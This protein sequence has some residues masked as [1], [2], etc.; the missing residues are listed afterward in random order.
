MIALL[1]YIV[2]GAAIFKAIEKKHEAKQIAAK[3]FQIRQKYSQI[4]NGSYSKCQLA[5]LGR[6]NEEVRKFL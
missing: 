2:S 5:K 4:A 1:A 6:H 3:M